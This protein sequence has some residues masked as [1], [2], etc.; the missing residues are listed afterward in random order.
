MKR[1]KALILVL[2]GFIGLNLSLKADTLDSIPTKEQVGATN[3]PQYIAPVKA[4]F[5][6]PAF[7]I[8]T[9]PNYK[10]SIIKK[11][12]KQHILA[13]RIIQS[14]IDA[15]SKRGGGTVIIPKGQWFTGRI[16]LKSNVNLHIQEGAVLTF[17]PNV[18]D[19]RPA[20]FTR[21]EGI[22]VMSLGALIYANGQHNIAITGKGKLVGP[23]DGS[24]R[25][26]TMTTDVIERVV[27]LDKPVSQRIYEGYNGSIIFPPMFISPINCSK[28][29]IEGVSLERTAF[30]NIVPVYCDNVIIRGVSVNSVGIPRGDGIDVESSRNVLIEYCTLATGDDCFT[31]KAGRGEDGIRVNKPTENVVVRHCL[32]KQ[33]HGGITCGSETAGMIRNLYVHD[34]VFD[35]TGV[36]IRFKTRR[37]R[38]GGGE[39]IIYE[40]IRMNLKAT[41]FNWDMLGGFAY[42]GE[43]ANRLPERAINRLTP[44]YKNIHIKDV[45]VEN[46]TQFLKVNAIPET[47]LTNL[48]IENIRVNADKLI[49]LNDADGILI[50]HAII[51]TKENG[52]NMLDGRNVRF[53]NVQFQNPAGA[54]DI[55]ID[56]P[57]SK[58]IQF[59]NCSPASLNK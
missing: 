43:L 16:T 42:V 32:A 4:P 31:I 8:P 36:G 51:K 14:C 50:K 21:N 27:P 3:L 15:T 38:A 23:A 25:K 57:K 17:S 45:I 24:V 10:I 9:F 44:Q 33:G 30:W 48:V 46:S 28:V 58:P 49:T 37:N 40:R 39:N 22:E 13:T 6:M 35:E 53:E 7:S 54:L 2:L 59:I 11:G 41:A 29:Y 5:A 52:V 20:V 19:Y 12:A 55:K 18:E 26:Q 56:G 47:P 34:C 1:I